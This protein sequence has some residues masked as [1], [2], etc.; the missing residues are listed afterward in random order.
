MSVIVCH[1]HPSGKLEPSEQDKH[2]TTRLKEA[3]GYLDIQ[4]L[5]HMILTPDGEWLS[6]VD[7]GIL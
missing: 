6:F 7:S 3:L 4:L 1:N 5:D 2:I